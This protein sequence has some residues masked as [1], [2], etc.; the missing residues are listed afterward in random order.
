M[1][2]SNATHACAPARPRTH[3]IRRSLTAH[4]LTRPV[5]LT[6]AAVSTQH[7]ALLSPASIAKAAI[8]TCGTATDEA[9]PG[10]GDGLEVVLSG[11][12]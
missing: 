5:M 10:V 8:T 7:T 3:A 2:S 6:A 4:G 1:R 9:S 11:T 12:S